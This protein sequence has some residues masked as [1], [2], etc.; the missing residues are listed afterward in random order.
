LPVI[1]PLTES[2]TSTTGKKVSFNVV[3]P[4][5]PGFLFSSV[6]PANW[7]IDDTARTYNTLMTEVL[8][9]PTYSVHG[10]DWVCCVDTNTYLGSDRASQGSVFGYALYSAFN[11]TVR[12]AQ[13]V[14]IPFFPPT[15]Q[16]LVDNN[17]TLSPIQ[18]VTEQRYIDWSM[19]GTG[20]LVVQTNK[21]CCGLPLRRGLRL[22]F[23]A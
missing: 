15:T 23:T 22:I 14:F 20:Y 12:A 3:V 21:V 6:P 17:I 16:D 5:L 11:T 18:Q 13:F 8:G 10:T 7:T 1:K 19:T 2:S 4:S 9:Y